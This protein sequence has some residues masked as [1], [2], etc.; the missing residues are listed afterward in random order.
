MRSGRMTL[1]AA[2]LLTA[3][4]APCRA[5]NLD[6]ALIARAG[7]LLEEVA[8]A[9]HKTVGV[10]PFRIKK[11]TRPASAPLAGSMP[12]RLENALIVVQGGTERVAVR[13]LRQP[14]EPAAAASREAFTVERDLAWGEGQ[15][16]PDALLTGEVVCA[17]DRKSATVTVELL[18]PKSWRDGKPAPR[19]LVRFKVDADVPLL[20]DLGHSFSLPRATFKRGARP[21]DA[22]AVVAA[23]AERVGPDNVGGMRLEAE[24]DGVRQKFAAGPDGYRLHS[25]KPGQKAVLYLTRVSDE[26][27][28]L[29][30]VLRVG[31]LSLFEEQDGDPASGRKWA[32]DPAKRGVRED[33]AGFYAKADGARPALKE[34]FRALSG[35]VELD[36]FGPAE[37]EGRGVSTRSLTTARARTLKELQARLARANHL[38]LRKSVVSARAGGLLLLDV[39]PA[40]ASAAEPSQTLPLGGLTVW[41]GSGE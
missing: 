4:A 7:Q 14:A 22:D 27:G 39:E 21:A 3:A 25:P 8:G 9:G 28:R 35:W 32:Y 13:V 11:G 30:A 15:A 29:G 36:V 38:S 40:V 2:L 41:V 24:Y 19:R 17:A 5:G 10:L 26:D 23:Q 12:G 6:R 34:P 1:I 20:R 31:G 16:R 18:D 37:P 33:F